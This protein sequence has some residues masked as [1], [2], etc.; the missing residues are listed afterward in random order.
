MS[1]LTTVF[2]SKAEIEAKIKEAEAKKTKEAQEAIAKEIKKESSPIDISAPSVYVPGGFLTLF[3]DCL[4]GFLPDRKFRGGVFEKKSLNEKD[5][6][7][8]K[9]KTYGVFFTPNG[10]GDIKNPKGTLLRHDGNVTRLNACFAD[11]DHGSKERQLS[12]IESMP[13]PYS[14]LIESKRGFHAYW[15]LSAP[16]AP[17]SAPQPFEP[18][19]LSLWRR[20]QTTIATKYGADKNCSNPS[21]LM[22]MP[23]SYHVK[24][25]PYLVEIR[26]ANDKIYTLSELE[27]AFPPPE[28]PIFSH[29]QAQTRNKQLRMP[30]ITA[31]SD[32]N[33]HNEMKA[34]A[35]RMYAHAPA[36][37]A[38]AIRNLLKCW[39]STSCINLKPDWEKETD[40]VCDW[41]ESREFGSILSTRTTCG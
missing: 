23:G 39:Y 40:D 10:H 38:E 34:T 20:V 14:L 27:I 37:N 32:G 3:P 16:S 35:G 25:D 12:I 33:R 28:R 2:L 5:L 6:I 4:F 24:G 26:Q 21:R 18:E 36:E 13:V 22:R 19:T 29:N 15:M 9:S 1:K 11:F 8:A 31:L 7:G 17:P 41:I 30:E